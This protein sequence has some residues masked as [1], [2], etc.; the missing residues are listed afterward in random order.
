MTTVKSTFEYYYVLRTLPTILKDHTNY[1]LIG[2]E[3][4]DE[5]FIQKAYQANR[6]ID[7]FLSELE[8]NMYIEKVFPYNV[9][10]DIYRGWKTFVA[11]LKIGA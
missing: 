3:F 6:S 10:A 9:L 2:K 11:A 4:K 5:L 1:V 7:M 8:F